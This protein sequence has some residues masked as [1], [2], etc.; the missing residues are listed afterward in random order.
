MCI[1]DSHYSTAPQSF[2][3][4]LKDHKAASLFDAYSH[5][6]YGSRNDRRVAPSERPNAPY[7][8]VTLYNLDVL[9]K[10]FPGKDLSLIHISEPT[11]LGMISYAVFC[12][13]KKKKKKK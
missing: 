13:K 8:E 1:R 12:L 4:Y 6:P 7:W 5:H 9:L 10:L 3:R 11:R 2:A